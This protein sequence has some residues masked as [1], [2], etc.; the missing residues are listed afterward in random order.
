[1]DKKIQSQNSI[2]FH[3][4]D[5]ESDFFE[6]IRITKSGSKWIVSGVAINTHCGCW[7]SFARKTGNPVLDKARYIKEIIRQKKEKTH[8]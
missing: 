7:S 8:E 3:T 4:R 2:T 5:S 1:M 6:S